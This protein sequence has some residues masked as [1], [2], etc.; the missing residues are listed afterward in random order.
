M[1]KIFFLNDHVFLIKYPQALIFLCLTI[2]V[3]NV[4]IANHKS[5][6]HKNKIPRYCINV[7]KKNYIDI[8]TKR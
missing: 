5:V 3:C 2:R 7:R 1:K 6:W 4:T 8:L